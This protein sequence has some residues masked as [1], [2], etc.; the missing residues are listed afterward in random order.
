M[1]LPF[2]SSSQMSRGRQQHA[3]ADA[4]NLSTFDGCQSPGGS[5]EEVG[6]VLLAAGGNSG[7][8]ARS[9]AVRRPRRSVP[10]A[11]THWGHGSLG[12]TLSRDL[13]GTGQVGYD[14]RK[15]L[16]HIFIS[17]DLR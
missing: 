9:R 13:L 11:E 7:S 3:C 12:G 14:R 16:S 17:E 2:L 1:G 8:S 4:W 5:T 6:A 15:F 10:Q